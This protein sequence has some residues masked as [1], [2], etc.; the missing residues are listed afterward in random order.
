MGKQV[1]RLED[2]ADLRSDA[3]DVEPGA[4]SDW[5]ST[6]TS[7][8]S[9]VS[10]RFRQR[11]SVDLPDPD[12]PITTTTS[13]RSTD[14]ETP[15]RTCNDPKNLWTSRTSIDRAVRPVAIRVPAA[16]ARGQDPASGLCC[17][18]RP[19]RRAWL[20]ATTAPVRS[21]P[22]GDDFDGDLRRRPKRLPEPRPGPPDRPRGG[23]RRPV[24]AATP[25]STNQTGASRNA[26]RGPRSV[27]PAPGESIDDDVAH[28]ARHHAVRRRGDVRDAHEPAGRGLRDDVGHERPVDRQEAAA[29]DADQARPDDQEPDRRRQR[30][31]RPSR[32]RWSRTRRR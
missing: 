29:A 27:A 8:R 18:P 7:P 10:S 20:D 12:G 16:V 28:E 21:Y 3:V 1:E 2:D 9:T 26:A 30:A 31:D 4:L 24:A 32:W 23:A 14:I 11:R 15:F 19:S 13:A 22:A 17:R 25:R 6:M 5:P